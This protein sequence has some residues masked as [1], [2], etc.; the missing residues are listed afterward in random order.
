MLNCAG[1]FGVTRKD[2]HYFSDHSK[3][4]GAAYCRRAFELCFSH[5]IFFLAV[6]DSTSEIDVN[7]HLEMGRDL[8]SR[9]QLQDALSHYHAAVGEFQ[10]DIVAKHGREL[11]EMFI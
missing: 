9:G 5:I 1:F 6:S 8:L 10:F 7:K 11:R 3:N 2:L 4:G